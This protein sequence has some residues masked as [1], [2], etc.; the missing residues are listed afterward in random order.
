M[1]SIPLIFEDIERGGKDHDHESGIEDD[2]AYRNNVVNAT[3]RIRMGFIRKVYGLLSLQLLL[4]VVIAGMCM[5]T[6]T[7]KEFIHTK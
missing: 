5:M 6:P 4:T 7:I 2:F 3:Q 1:A